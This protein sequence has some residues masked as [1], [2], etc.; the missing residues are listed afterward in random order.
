MQNR[1]R[2]NRRELLSGVAG[3]I[4]FTHVVPSSALGSDGGIAASE[5]ITMGAIG[6]GGRGRKIMEALIGRKDCRMVAVCDVD[7]RRLDQAR[8]I[9]N[10]RYGNSDCAAYSDY[11]ELLARDDIDAVLIASP[12]Q[13]HGHH[14]S[15]LSSNCLY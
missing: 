8:D 14:C 1:I 15:E 3:I 11:R 10:S 12:D 7:S 4:A 5:R 2:L 9:V 13:W 6:V